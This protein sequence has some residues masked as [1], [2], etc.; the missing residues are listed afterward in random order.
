MKKNTKE[1]IKV[2]VGVSGGKAMYDVA[3]EVLSI[4]DKTAFTSLGAVALKMGFGFLG[5]SI[6][7]KA[8][9]TCEKIGSAAYDLAKEVAGG[10][11]S[12]QN[13]EEK[14]DGEETDNSVTFTEVD[15]E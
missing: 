7:Y 10:I 8:V 4:T 13:K 12:A 15:D 9:D 1:L 6:S 14:D 2:A 11:S 5:F 3:R